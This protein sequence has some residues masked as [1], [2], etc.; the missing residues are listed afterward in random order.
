MLG[1]LERQLVQLPERSKATE[2]AWNK[3][4]GNKD[5]QAQEGP[6]HLQNTCH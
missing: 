6:G 1:H 4:H 3:K 2:L 5:M